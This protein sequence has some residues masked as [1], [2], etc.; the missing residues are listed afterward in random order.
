MM[1]NGAHAMATMKIPTSPHYAR[2]YGGMIDGDSEGPCVVCGRPVKAP[3]RLVVHVIEGGN[4]IC[5][6]EEDARY[7]A[8][9]GDMGEQPLGAECAK[10]FPALKPYV[11]RR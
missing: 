11:R 10:R 3:A 9:A 8:T 6:P 5:T 4:T 2:R 1:K 7:A